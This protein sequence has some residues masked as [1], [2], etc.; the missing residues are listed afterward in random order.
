MSVPITCPYCFA[1][2][3]DDQV[4][5]RSDRVSSRE[6]EIIPDEFD[7]PE[8]FQARYR[9]ADKEEILSRYA[10]WAFFSEKDPFSDPNDPYA[11]FWN[12][13]GGVT[14]ER[15]SFEER[16]GLL[17]YHRPV[18]DPSDPAH[19]RYLKEQPDGSVFVRDHSD[20]VTQ[21]TLKSGES[22]TCRVCRYC[23][24]PLPDGYGKN[25]VK[26]IALVGVTGS[27]K[28]VYLSQL[29]KRM[30]DY[31]ANV[32]LDVTAAFRSAGEFQR[33]NRITVGRM[34]PSPTPFQQFQQP[35][36]YELFGMDADG[37]RTT[38]TL[39][40]YDVAGELF[41]AGNATYLDRFAPF[42]RHADGIIV[43]VDPT[44]LESV[45]GAGQLG[46]ENSPAAALDAIQSIVTDERGALGCTKPVA[47]CLSQIDREDA[48]RVLGG[49]LR[50]MLNARV[51]PVTDEQGLPRRVFNAEQHR[52]IA[53][54]IREFLRENQPSL[55]TKLDMSFPDHQYFAFTSLG[56]AVEDGKPVGPIIPKRIEEPLYWLLCKLGLLTSNEEARPDCPRCKTNAYAYRL[57]HEGWAAK[58]ICKAIRR[59]WGCRRCGKKW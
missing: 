31:A 30:G 45:S 25:P 19:R 23:H 18:I 34:L 42:I 41:E 27:G 10:E 33:E 13:Y 44:Q 1:E 54:K 57:P 56:C 49:D 50:R 29:L 8:D 6:Q 55:V 11:R 14:T 51:E 32:G 21:I 47:V 28:T 17:P 40:L 16:L 48:Q 24:N 4:L 7:D 36:F 15:D 38:D 9:G 35:L 52:P 20:M 22:C 3:E 12:Q 58:M 2:M 26:S 5:F 39:V 46:W 43:L 37:E 59:S 53:E